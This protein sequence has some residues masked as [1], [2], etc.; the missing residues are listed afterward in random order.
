MQSRTWSA[1]DAV[2]TAWNRDPN[3]LTDG[4]YNTPSPG[5]RMP[6]RRRLLRRNTMDALLAAGGGFTVTK[7]S[8]VIFGAVIAAVASLVGALMASLVALRNEKSCQ[9]H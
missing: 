5:V 2:P 1:S 4:D 3:W 6:D 9:Q 8:V 7:I